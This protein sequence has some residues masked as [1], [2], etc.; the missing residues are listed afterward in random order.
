GNGAPRKAIA[1]AWKQ[2][3]DGAQRRGE[4]RQAERDW[5]GVDAWLD[6]QD[7][8]VTREQLADFIRANE[9][10]V[11]DVVL[12][13]DVLTAG[14]ETPL[15]IDQIE[16]IEDPEDS[17]FWMA[18]SP[19]GNRLVGKKHYPTKEAAADFA[20]RYFNGHIEER[21]RERAVK[22][23]VTPKYESYQLPGG[24]N[25]RELLLT[26]PEKSNAPIDSG[27]SA[28]TMLFQNDMMEKYGG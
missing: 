14:A 5:L 26:L 24:Q 7:K 22:A 8:P 19:A 16:I 2:W 15:T 27:P 9:V 13:R 6:A 18:D 11:R 17:E 4:F 20:L 10:Q 12:G 3:L 21:N 25:Y 23:G 28:A 1:A